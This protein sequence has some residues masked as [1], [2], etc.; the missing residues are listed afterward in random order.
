MLPGLVEKSRKM[1]LGKKIVKLRKLY[2]W[3]QE[4]LAVQSGL[5]RSHISRLEK[6][7]FRKPSADSLFRLA[8]AFRIQ[9]RELFHA[10]G[11]PVDEV[12]PPTDLVEKLD[13]DIRVFLSNDWPVM[14]EQERNLVRRILWAVKAAKDDRLRTEPL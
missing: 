3:T 10:L 12:Y 14:N 8:Q 9:P 7:D 1:T 4:D 13:I 6:D 2:G 5:K 11:Y